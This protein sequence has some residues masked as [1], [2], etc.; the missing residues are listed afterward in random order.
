MTI[1]NTSPFPRHHQ[2][3][4]RIFASA[5]VA[6][7]ICWNSGCSKTD[8]DGN[9]S[10]PE[11][12]AKKSDKAKEKEAAAGK[13]DFAAN[14]VQP[15]PPEPPLH[16]WE[17]PKVAFILTGEQNGYIEPCGCSENQLGGYMR[18]ATLID[19]LQD[20][21][22]KVAGFELGGMVKRTRRQSEI[23]W[24]AM[25][26]GLKS[27]N[28]KTVGIGPSEIRLGADYLLVQ[29]SNEVT[30]KDGLTFISANVVLFESPGLGIQTH[31]L[32]E[33]DGVKV[34]VTS[35]V[36]DD[37]RNSIFPEGAKVDVA[38]TAPMTALKPVVAAIEKLGADLHVLM[39][40][41]SIDES[42]ALAKAYP[43]FDLI[44]SSGGPEDPDGKPQMVG[45]TMLVTVGRKGKH[46]GV[47]GYYPVAEKSKLK[48]GLVTLDEQ[49]FKDSKRIVEFMKQYQERLL[50]EKLAGTEPAIAH[51]SGAKFMGAASCK[52]CHERTYEKW[53][54]TGHAKAFESL[55]HPR[56]GQPDY[57]ITRIYDAECI[58]CHVTGW[59]PQNVVRFE[60]GFLNAEFS[61]GK[62]AKERAKLLEGQQCESCHGPASRHIDLIN[63]GEEEAALKEV[64]I[65]KAEARDKTC[66]A[67][68]DLDNSP[69]FDFDKYWELVKH[70]WRD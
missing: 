66:Y 15:K 58:A 40:F 4:G 16:D 23:K 55:K 9:S 35:I 30:K 41:S 36:G 28:Y 13:S 57:G 61:E 38:T 37:I 31:K 19:Q 70:P 56:A 6:I 32:V 25:L 68:H 52:E 21:G 7:C 1:Q 3:F 24:E 2:A 51:P 47:V 10:L 17:K 43:L 22:W 49:R 33:V 12:S 5:V 54:S 63:A 60:S 39:S 8:A 45:N 27:M 29:A 11:K 34:A 53:L 67:C 64:R 48:F 44:V 42:T 65:T 69:K 14:D 26:S 46:T 20:R 18:R 62:Q 50:T 59:D